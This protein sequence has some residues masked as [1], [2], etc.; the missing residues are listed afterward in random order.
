L[1]TES[2]WEYACRAGT[3][4]IYSFADDVKQLGN[5]AWYKENTRHSGSRA[6]RQKKPNGFGL[7]DMHGNAWEWCAD[8]Y[9]RNAYTTAKR[10]DPL[11]TIEDANRVLRGG[12]WGDSAPYCRSAFRCALAPKNWSG[13]IGFR[14]CRVP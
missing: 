5:Y 1:P 6:V 10:T 2:Q 9:S 4:S 14:V 13:D 7:Y 11:V 3:K 8:S 12:R